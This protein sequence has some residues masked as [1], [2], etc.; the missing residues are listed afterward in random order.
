MLLK[1]EKRRSRRKFYTSGLEF[2][3][4]GPI[5]QSISILWLRHFCAILTPFTERAI[6][7]PLSLTDTT[8]SKRDQSGYMEKIIRNRLYP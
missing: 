4:F 5:D 7:N 1:L 8:E 3:Y 2:L 6:Q